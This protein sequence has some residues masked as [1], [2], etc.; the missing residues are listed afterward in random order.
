MLETMR[1]YGR[2]HLQ[3]GGASDTIR[4]RHARYTADTLC[5]LSLRLFGPDEYWIRQRFVEHLADASAA[6]D[7]FVEH[8][9]WQQCL[10]FV[11]GSRFVAEPESLEL[12]R[13]MSA[14]GKVFGTDPDVIDEVDELWFVDEHDD[15][16]DR[17]SLRRLRAP[18]PVR[19]RAAPS[20]HWP[21]N[22]LAV[23]P[24]SRASPTGRAIG[25]ARSTV[26]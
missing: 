6:R 20:S 5:A 9:D 4:E 23:Q 15:D 14:A 18:Y 25:L 2:E 22:P 21:S 7:W 16:A 17:R 11:P 1:A 3:H 8:R 26:R 12:C 24:R 10:R 19:P 13:R